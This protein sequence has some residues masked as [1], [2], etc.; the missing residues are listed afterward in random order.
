MAKVEF[1]KL[2][3]KTS[4]PDLTTRITFQSHETP[5]VSDSVG[6]KAEEWLFD[7]LLCIAAHVSFFRTDHPRNYFLQPR[8]TLDLAT[9]FIL[10]L[11]GKRDGRTDDWRRR[12][13]GG[14]QY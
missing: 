13:A 7:L 2:N 9:G 12:Q 10:P 6:E 5:I 8:L 3:Q 4:L 11:R 1:D 14:G